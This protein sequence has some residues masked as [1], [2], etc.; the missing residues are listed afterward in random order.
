MRSRS[1]FQETLRLGSWAFLS[2]VIPQ[3]VESGEMPEWTI[4]PI[5]QTD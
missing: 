4:N 1:P 3:T 5:E 2:C